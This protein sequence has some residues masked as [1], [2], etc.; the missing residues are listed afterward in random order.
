MFVIA[1]SGESSLYR[2]RFREDYPQPDPRG[3][4]QSRHGAPSRAVSRLFRL[5]DFVSGRTLNLPGLRCNRKTPIPLHTAW[6]R[7]TRRPA[8]TTDMPRRELT[9]SSCQ[10][11]LRIQPAAHSTQ[12]LIMIH[13]KQATLD[14]ESMF[15]GLFQA[16][17]NLGSICP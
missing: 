1:R 4:V 2:D 6:A 13:A 3:R 5:R 7:T 11:T 14:L 12:P 8:A 17:T 16:K 9:H 10:Y 15:E